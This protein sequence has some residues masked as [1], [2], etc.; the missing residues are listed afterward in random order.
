MA[1][2][3][4]ADILSCIGNVISTPNSYPNPWNVTTKPLYNNN[5]REYNYNEIILT[6][7][8]TG[9]HILCR[10]VNETEHKLQNL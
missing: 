4:P 7:P 3:N 2:N 5:I 9:I 10:S 8:V 1:F 6:Q